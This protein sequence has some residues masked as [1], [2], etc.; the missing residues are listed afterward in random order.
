MYAHMMSLNGWDKLI[1][2]ATSRANSE[3]RAANN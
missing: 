3:V 1:G 2:R